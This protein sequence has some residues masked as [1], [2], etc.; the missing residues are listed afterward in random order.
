MPRFADQSISAFLDALASSDPTPGGGTASAIAAAMGT[1][2]LMMVASLKKTRAN[3]DEERATLAEARPGLSAVRDRLVGLADA[4]SN[5]YEQVLAAYRLPKGSDAEKQA[6]TVAVQHA[7]RAATE[8][9]LE[10]L[11]ATCEAVRGARVVALHG[12]PAAASDTRVALELL[13]AAAAGAGANVEINLKDLTDETFRKAS[14]SA[15]IELSTK[16]KENI[17]TA[18]AALKPT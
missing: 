1:S 18:R 11:R 5:S 8:A 12:N 10:I 15:M 3:T 4:D 13:E 6:R 9:P 2:L 14:A 7:M 16:L 17:A